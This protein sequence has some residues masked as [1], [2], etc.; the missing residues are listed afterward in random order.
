M[1]KSSIILGIES[2][3]DDTSVA[4]CANGKILSNIICNQ[5]VHQHYGGVVP[6]LASRAHLSHIIPTIDDAIKSAG[7]NLS[8]IDAIAVTAGP[9]LIGSL[10]VGVC[11]AKGLAAAL[12]KPLIDVNHMQA[13]LLSNFIDDPLPKFPCISLTVSGGH[14]QLSL[15]HSPMEWDIIGKTIDDAAGE[16]FD[17]SGKL[18]SL[19]YPAGPI[20]D[21]LS[22]GGIAKFQFSKS[23]VVGLDFSFSGL[24][25]SVLYFLRDQLKKNPKF[26]EQNKADLCASIQH[27][28]VEML[29]E[30]LAK[31]AED[32]N[33]AEIAVAGGVSANSGLRS[34]V[35]EMGSERGWNV[36]FPA[37]QYCMDN[38]AMIALTAYYKYQSGSFSNLE[39]TPFARQKL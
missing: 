19:D 6:E 1:N 31:A 18:L 30:K 2:S 7:V 15:M 37:M 35:L 32:Y 28:I 25:T 38:A 34:K 5:D 29:V 16:A 3:C 9:G 21:K 23:R 39:L 24:K 36:Y 11:T 27:V 22:K 26:I 17:K 10:I 20:V 13:H 33:I 14:T 4:V 12:G 8:D